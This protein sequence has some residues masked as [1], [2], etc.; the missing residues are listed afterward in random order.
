VRAVIRRRASA[1][2]Y[3]PA[4]RAGAGQ[5]ADYLEHKQ[6]YLEHK[7]DYLDYPAFPAAGWPVASGLIEGAAR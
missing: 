2:G 3:S 7:Q 5:C 6:D 4:G 1:Y